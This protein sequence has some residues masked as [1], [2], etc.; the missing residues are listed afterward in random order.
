MFK[1][2]S[3]QV[4]VNSVATQREIVAGIVLETLMP[5]PFWQA[6]TSKQKKSFS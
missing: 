4:E 1:R 5:R 2:N 3:K 6:H